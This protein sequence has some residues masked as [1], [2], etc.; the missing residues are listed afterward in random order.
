M[1]SVPSI[2]QQLKTLQRECADAQFLNDF[3]AAMAGRVTVL[4]TRNDSTEAVWQMYEL[5]RD[6]FYFLRVVT[7]KTAEVCKGIIWSKEVGNPTVLLSLTRSFFEHIASLCYQA[8]VILKIENAIKKQQNDSDYFL[9]EI[10]RHREIIDKMYYGISPKA[11]VPKDKGFHV[12]DFIKSMSKKYGI[13]MLDYDLLSDFVHPNFGSNSLVSSGKLGSGKMGDLAD[14]HKK[15]VEFANQC[16]AKCIQ[17]F[18][19]ANY[20]VSRAIIS[21]DGKG[22]ELAK[23]PKALGAI[24][25]TKTVDAAGDGLSMETAFS[26]PDIPDLT[27]FLKQ[28]FEYLLERGH[29]PPSGRFDPKDY[30]QDGF[31]YLEFLTTDGII[32]FMAPSNL[33]V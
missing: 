31:I 32:W 14:N 29:R 9:Y 13:S 12:G 5:C 8:S 30:E 28:S 15:H 4:P 3:D 16:I 24:F 25:M 33:D 1:A 22:Q 17:A 26:F 11:S 27:A 2:I 10:G 6:H 20:D 21:L 18:N 19:S 7:L 23:K